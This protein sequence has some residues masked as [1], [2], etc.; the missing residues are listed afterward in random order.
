MNTK[1]R[2]SRRQ[3]VRLAGFT[4]G[5]AALAACAT[6]TPQVIK[7]TVVVEK[8]VKETVVV[9]PTPTKR[10]GGGYPADFKAR[11]PEW[12]RL[13][14]DHK[15]GTLVTQKEWY[16]ILGDPPAEEI[17]GAFWLEGWG[18]AW[19]EEVYK[20][21]Q[22]MHPGVKMKIWGDP[23]IWDTLRP[24]LVAEDIPDIG[25][26]WWQE[27]QP[28]QIK[29]AQEGILAP[30]DFIL[31]VEAY[32]QSGK[33]LEETLAVGAL[34]GARMSLDH[35]F[36]MP[37]V[38]TQVG[39]Y[40][41]AEMFEKNGW[42]QPDALTWEEFLDDLCPKIKKAGIAP[43]SWPGKVPGYMDCITWG[44]VYKKAGGQAICDIDNLK[45]GAWKNPDIVWALGQMQEFAKRD[46]LYPG[47]EAMNHTEAQQIFV[48]GKAA[49]VGCGSWL[50]REMEATTPPG[51]RMKLSSVPAP[52]E[53]KGHRK[54]VRNSPGDAALM[55]GNGKHPLW[56]MEF[57][58]LT[59]SQMIGRYIAQSVGG[60]VSLQDPFPSGF[61]ADETL[62]S[63]LDAVK[64]AE[65]HFVDIWAMNY[66]G[67]IFK[68]WWDNEGD[69]VL[70]K[71]SVENVIDLIERAA[72]EI[73]E[74][75]NVKKTPFD[76][77]KY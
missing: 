35:Q 8:P 73:R 12:Q 67:G 50:K 3:F 23:R 31:D 26:V 38:Q 74:D 2:I 27:G 40:Y 9:Q 25:H 1:S 54:A 28:A 18:M 10:P 59:L 64:A 21:M 61:K 7:E 76:C 60:M 43:L 75:P 16:E 33:R 71:M 19:K 62:Q 48:D 6:P 46:F 45:E 22:L 41:N 4:A 39:I 52:K 53:S 13:P 17:E 42:P 32:G 55:V 24:R 37:W 51:F 30:V 63:Q 5:A 58:R 47:N 36:A 34:S 70:G 77:S 56:G 66:Y 69:F 44:L 11:S 14:A 57:I 20:L 68:P 65:G 72:K 29:A 15:P 49:M